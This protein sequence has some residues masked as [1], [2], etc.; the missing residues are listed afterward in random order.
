LHFT[1]FLDYDKVV[2]KILSYFLFSFFVLI[3]LNT[4]LQPAFGAGTCVINLNPNPLDNGEYLKSTKILMTVSGLD[5]DTEYNFKVYN[6]NGGGAIDKKFKTP[7]DQTYQSYEFN[8]KDIVP[9]NAII[10]IYNKKDETLLCEKNITVTEVQ[11]DNSTAPCKQVSDGSEVY[12]TCSTGFG[13][14]IDTRP[15]GF[16][17]AMFRIVLSISGGIATLLII[18]SGYAMIAS[19][20][21]PEKIT[22]AREKL[23]S[24]I[25]GL[26]FIIF[27]LVILQIIGVDIL[28]IL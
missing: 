5:I 18:F 2:R 20:G 22:A 26:L 7:S 9:G 3:F 10:H 8:T 21:N 14:T 17:T 15:T 23:T 1:V 4:A 11:K 27:S 19:R 12:Y 6:E 24:A 25:V 28:G 16:V 13:V